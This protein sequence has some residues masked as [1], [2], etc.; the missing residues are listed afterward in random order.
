MPVR[1]DERLL[2]RHVVKA[3]VEVY[4]MTVRM[5]GRQW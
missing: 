2:G 4:H 1:P 5:D 3:I